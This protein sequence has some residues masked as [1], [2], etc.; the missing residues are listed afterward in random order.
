MRIVFTFRLPRVDASFGVAGPL[1][2]QRR[3]CGLSAEGE[4]HYDW[5]AATLPDIG[6]AEHGYNF[7]CSC[8]AHPVKK[9]MG[10]LTSAS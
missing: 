5:A 1:V 2:W 3:S 8:A 4:H 7:G 6:A 10:F 9:L